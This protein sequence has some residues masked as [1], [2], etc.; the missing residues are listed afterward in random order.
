M[1]APAVTFGQLA[2]LFK[3]IFTAAGTYRNSTTH[4]LCR[5]SSSRTTTLLA[6]DLPCPVAAESIST[7]TTELSSIRVYPGSYDCRATSRR[8]CPRGPASLHRHRLRRR[9]RQSASEM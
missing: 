3:Q 5:Q 8:D 1:A 9:Q 4:T 6:L 2:L 7:A